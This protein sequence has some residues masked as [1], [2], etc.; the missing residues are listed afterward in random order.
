MTSFGPPGKS[1]AQ[2]TSENPVPPMGELWVEHD[3]G[4]VKRGNG[5]T[6]WTSLSYWDPSGGT[7]S[8]PVGSGPAMFGTAGEYWSYPAAH[9]TGAGVDGTMITHAVWVPRTVV[10]DRIGA[11][12]TVGAASST[13]TL[14]IY[15]DDGVGNPGTLL[16]DA[17]TIDG[18]SATAQEITINKR[19]LGGRIYHL[20]CLVDAGTPTIRTIGTSASGW[21][22]RQAS[23]ANALGA[24]ANRPGR[25]QTGIVGS[26]LPTTAATTAAAGAPQL[27]AVRFA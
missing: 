10:I 18:N 16:F 17:G 19:L 27:V 11:E 3:T 26:A 6:A 4:Y 1:A 8:A 24:G 2:L 25:T 20:A 9:S 14:G 5:H 23:L 12:V 15:Q 7:Y 13:L 22:G 21:A